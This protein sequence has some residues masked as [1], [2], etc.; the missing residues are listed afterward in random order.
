MPPEATA[1]S[2]T[3]SIIGKDRP[4]VD[5]P[6]KVTGRALYSSDHHFPGMLYAVPVCSTIARGT[7]ES[8]DTAAAEKMP[9]VKAVFRRG[10]IGRLFRAKVNFGE[11]MSMVDE[12]RVPF[13]DD[14]IN[15]YGQYV[16]LV[17][18]ESFEQASAAADVVKATYKTA[19][20]D[21]S[22]EFDLKKLDGL[23]KATAKESEDPTV[24]KV[25]TERGEPEKVF[26]TS[27]IQL[28][29]T[30]TV[31]VETHNPIELH[32]TVAVWEG[33]NVT[34]Y[35]STQAVVNARNVMAQVLG[36][37]RE[38]VRVITKFLGSGFGGKLWP[39]PHCALAAAA[40]RELQLPVKL[41]LTR[42]MMFQNVGHRPALQQRFRLSATAEGKLTSLRHEYVNHTSIL[43]DYQENCGEATAH[44]YSVPNL[45]V[46]SARARRN[47]GTPTSMRGPGA[48]PGLFG[49]ESAMDELAVQLKMDPVKFRLLN[50]P[51]MDESLKL[52]F[53]SRHLAECYELGGKQFGWEN[54]SAAVGSMRDGDDI[55]GWGMAACTWMAKRLGCHARVE[56]LEDGSARVSTASQDIGTGTYTVL[57]QVVSEKLRLPVE[58]IEV[59]IGDSALPSGPLSGGSMATA[60][61]IPAVMEAAGK[62]VKELMSVATKTPGSKLEGRDASKLELADGSVRDTD[63]KD[64]VSISELLSLAKLR[65]VGGEG[66][67]EGTFGGE[68]PPKVSTHYFGAHIIEVRW[69]PQIARLRVS[70]VVTAI[71]AGRIINPLAGRNQIEGAVVMG[72][73]MALFEETHYEPRTGAPINASLADYVIA[74]NAD[75]PPI[76]VHFLTYPDKVLNELGARGIGEIGLA[77]TAAAITNAIYHATGLRFRKIPVTIEDLLAAPLVG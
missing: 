19:K 52:P 40:A 50:E 74:V 33:P 72:I 70:K 77:G 1:M 30:Y 3:D 16:A 10:N 68:K 42:R 45:R 41:V 66:K 17:V 31:P 76:D 37:P 57:A 64:A 8:L 15:Y 53:S 22:G 59:S 20:H 69:Q 6:V 48:V 25:E 75:V 46:T 2:A 56:I 34:L 67:S 43:D 47:V 26:G 55:L 65:S 27:P 5:G 14:E 63:G 13:E 32:A 7:L 61:V 29:A 12:Q 71:D 23:T 28:D 39:W 54:R 4:R 21:T 36:V 49:L 11:D 62:A 9:G 51:A 18:A 60:S 58:K 35:E 73:G 38:N 24:P 44:M